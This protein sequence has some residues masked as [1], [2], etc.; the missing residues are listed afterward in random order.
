M[1]LFCGKAKESFAQCSER[2]SKTKAMSR[3]LYVTIIAA[4]A[5]A[6]VAGGALFYSGDEA[7]RADAW[8]LPVIF[9]M[10]WV[11]VRHMNT[12]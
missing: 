1:V 12:P 8:Y 9:I 11:T 7:V 3:A 6:L 5:V 4:L 2:D 10:I